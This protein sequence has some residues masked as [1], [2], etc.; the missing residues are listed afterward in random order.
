ML[1][2]IWHTQ[3]CK[4]IFMKNVILWQTISKKTHNKPEICTLKYMIL[5]NICVNDCMKWY[6]YLNFWF[7]HFKN[8]LHGLA[9][10]VNSVKTIIEKLETV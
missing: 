4:L 1:I 9:D 3:K 2:T 8:H 10:N 7:H 6:W 5:I